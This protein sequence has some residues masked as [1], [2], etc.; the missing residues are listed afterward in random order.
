MIGC[1]SLDIGFIQETK[2]SVDVM[3]D[4]ALGVCPHG[5]CQCVGS[6]GSFGGVAFFLDLR[7]V[8]PLWWILIHSSISMNASSLE[9]GE[10]CLF[11]NVYAPIDLLS[12]SQLWTH[13]SY[14]FSLAPWNPWI[15]ARYFNVVSGFEEKRVIIAKLD[16]FSF[17]LIDNMTSLNLVVVKPNND[18]FTWNNQRYSDVAISERLDRIHAYCFLVEDSQT[19]SSNILDWI[20]SD[21]YLIKLSIVPF[22]A[23][24]NPSFKF[25]LMWLWDPSLHELMLDW[26]HKGRPTYGMDMYSFFKR[27]QYVKYRLKKWNMWCFGNLHHNKLLAQARLDSI[28]CQIH[29]LGILVDLCREEA[30]ATK[31]LEEWELREEL[32][33]KKKSQ[34]DWLKEGDRNTS[35]FHHSIFERRNGNL[36][37]SPMS[38]EG[39]QLSS[40]VEFSQE[41]SKFFST[42]FTEDSPPMGMEENSILSCIPSLVSHQ[43]NEALFHLIS[44]L[45]LETI[46]FQI[47]KGKSPSP[48]GFPVDFF[49]CF[50]GD[51]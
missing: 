25:Q 14:V 37:N 48:N 6:F 18:I 45:E 47:K 11:T 16:P 44:L 20:G 10:S 46:V 26:R 9:S 28:T 2:F 24:K 49:L 22:R 12:K 34:I 13:I 36:I 33:W 3:M 39:V 42:L 21:Y 50:L 43:R 32:F 19:T 1:H 27:L 51:Y 15:V 41:P 8:V 40:Q 17:L 29:D 31:A 30:L 38:S 4:R 23:H 5:C 7:K 35:F